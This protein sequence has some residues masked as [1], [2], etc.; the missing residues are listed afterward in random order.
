MKLNKLFITTMIIA[1]M[2]LAGCAELKTNLEDIGKSAKE[3]AVSRAKMEAS[4]KA[5]EATG[6]ILGSKY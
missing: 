2:S 3:S 1:S 5:S 4:Q 6:K